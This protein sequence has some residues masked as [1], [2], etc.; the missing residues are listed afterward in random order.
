MF[1][2]S[3]SKINRKYTSKPVNLY[4]ILG[5]QDG[6][7]LGKVPNST[8]H[9]L[10]LIINECLSSNRLGKKLVTNLRQILYVFKTPILL[11]TV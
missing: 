2:G 5:K 7:L 4:H 10:L 3:L 6:K 9:P 1:P 8:G 11:L